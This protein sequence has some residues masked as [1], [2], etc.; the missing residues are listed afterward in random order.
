MTVGTK[1]PFLIGDLRYILIRRVKISI[2]IL[3]LGG[4]KPASNRDDILCNKTNMIYFH[5]QILKIQLLEFFVSGSCSFLQGVPLP[6]ESRVITPLIMVIPQ[7][8]IYFRPFVGVITPLITS[9]GPPCKGFHL[10]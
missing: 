1:T 3:V 5:K 4:L 9:R 2:V 10:A 6:V 8:P 7:L